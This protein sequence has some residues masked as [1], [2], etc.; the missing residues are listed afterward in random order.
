MCRHCMRM[1]QLISRPRPE[2]FV[3]SRIYDGNGAILCDAL[4]GVGVSNDLI[5]NGGEMPLEKLSGGVTLL[6]PIRGFTGKVQAQI[7]SDEMRQVIRA[8]AM[9]LHMSVSGFIK[10]ESRDGSSTSFRLLRVPER[11]ANSILSCEQCELLLYTA[12]Q[13]L[14]EQNRIAEVRPGP[15]ESR[16][17]T[18][19]AILSGKFGNVEQRKREILKCVDRGEITRNDELA[20]VLRPLLESSSPH[21]K[22][23]P[24]A[25]HLSEFFDIISFDDK[26]RGLRSWSLA[27]AIGV[28]RVL[29]EIRCSFGLTYGEI[30]SVEAGSDDPAQEYAYYL[31]SHE[32]EVFPGELARIAQVF[33]HEKVSFVW[34]AAVPK[35]YTIEIAKD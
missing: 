4:F 27:P 22:L 17:G 2:H 10:D 12:A 28:G 5:A 8:A 1:A 23:T 7:R 13:I 14:A 9:R 6:G 20:P 25:L 34:S 21:T 19:Q 15:Q 3:S 33:D 32:K 29:Q 18:Y 30:F 26:I 24:F 11:C 16:I 31:S 35:S